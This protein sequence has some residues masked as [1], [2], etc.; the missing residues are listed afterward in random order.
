MNQVQIVSDGHANSVPQLAPNELFHLL[1]DNRFEAAFSAGRIINLINHLD[2]FR[3]TIGEQFS[4]IEV[5]YFID[6][7]EKCCLKLELPPAMEM[8]ILESISQLTDS[9]TPNHDDDFSRFSQYRAETLNEWLADQ[10][11]S[12]FQDVWISR[13]TRSR[14]RA[15]EMEPTN[16]E[17]LS[18]IRD[19]IIGDEELSH[20][21]S[22]GLQLD[23]VFRAVS[24]DGRFQKRIVP[25]SIPLEAASSLAVEP[26]ITIVPTP[27]SQ[28][29]GETVYYCHYVPGYLLINIEH[30]NLTISR[31]LARHLKVQNFLTHDCD[32][33][34][35]DCEQMIAEAIRNHF[36]GGFS[37][38]WKLY[39]NGQEF[40]RDGKSI[41]LNENQTKIVS[42]L[43]ASRSENVENDENNL[44]RFFVPNSSLLNVL[45]QKKDNDFLRKELCRLNKRLKKLDVKIVSKTINKVRCRCITDLKV[46]S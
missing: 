10:N 38:R 42:T 13:L 24:L 31:L 33:I 43:L 11:D 21:I 16:A 4:D 8:A 23:Q 44:D 17:P 34:D 45:G 18:A 6:L 32:L 30:R 27:Q 35:S 40:K 14:S 22:F 1:L 20:W 26:M 25:R 5:A 3:H 28:V 29:A 12:S 9:L 7:L 39:V 19:A 41:T 37:K 36:A 15:P 46:S 2:A